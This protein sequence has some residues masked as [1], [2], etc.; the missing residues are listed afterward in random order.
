[1]VTAI[2]VLVSLTLFA[3]VVTALAV[4]R[5][6]EALKT[7]NQAFTRSVAEVNQ[8]LSRL[9]ANVQEEGLET[10]REVQLA[11]DVTTSSVE[12]LYERTVTKLKEGLQ[13]QVKAP[14]KAKPPA[15]PKKAP[16]KK[17]TRTKPKTDAAAKKV[18]AK[19]KK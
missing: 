10:R 13:P 19:T 2:F 5:R 8:N 17:R 1:M 14:A 4:S 3:L 18:S 7:T 9:Q 16:A 15:A 6:L 11:Q 12:Q